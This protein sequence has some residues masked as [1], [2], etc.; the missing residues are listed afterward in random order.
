MRASIDNINS[1][2]AF[3]EDFKASLDTIA[4]STYNESSVGTIK[5][6]F[7]DTV[8]RTDWEDDVKHV[9]NDNLENTGRKLDAMSSSFTSGNFKNIR[10]NTNNII[11]QYSHLVS[12]KSQY[13]SVVSKI[14]NTTETD[15]NKDYV[16]SLKS[17]KSSLY[18]KMTNDIDI[19]NRYIDEYKRY[20]FEGLSG[21]SAEAPLVIDYDPSIDTIPEAPP[22]PPPAPT[23][24]QI[25]DDTLC[26]YP[27]VYDSNGV[28]AYQV[29][30][31]RNFWAGEGLFGGDVQDGFLF[32]V[33][34]AD[35][36]V[37]YY[38][39]PTS[40]FGGDQI[41]V[42]TF[43]S[44]IRTATFLAQESVVMRCRNEGPY[45]DYYGFEI[46][47]VY[48]SDSQHGNVNEAKVK[49]FLQQAIETDKTTRG[50]LFNVYLDAYG[51]SCGGVY[52]GEAYRGP[53]G[54]YKAASGYKA[55]GNTPRIA[56]NFSD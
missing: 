47:L 56:G 33:P 50:F 6:G 20:D 22:P 4:S 51:R 29:S 43:D 5:Q 30:H 41:N 15:D 31:G 2:K 48:H 42:D 26:G 3:F 32:F 44:Y 38:F 37:Y 8:T 9:I 11:D 34:A 49:D 39:V 45:K 18:G 28:T 24:P 17:T 25:G 16:A 14:N 7:L 21:L 12:L 1:D 27:K 13:D 36:G 53:S 10:L 54:G 35:G 46:P 23:G 19:I 40:T 55:R 52:Y